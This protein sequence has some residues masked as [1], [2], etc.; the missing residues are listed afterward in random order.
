MIQEARTL[1]SPKRQNQRFH[2]YDR[3]NKKNNY[4]IFTPS[5][6][7]TEL[8][9]Y[10]PKT[11]FNEFS[12]ME[13]NS[14]CCKSFQTLNNH[15]STGKKSRKNDTDSFVKPFGLNLQNLQSESKRQQASYTSH[16]EQ[17]PHFNFSLKSICLDTKPKKKVLL[18]TEDIIMER[19]EK[20]KLEIEK[21]KRTN[22]ENI[23]KM[24]YGNFGTT[25]LGKKRDSFNSMNCEPFEKKSYEL[26]NS[27]PLKTEDN[28]DNNC[29]EDDFLSLTDNISKLSVMNSPCKESMKSM[30]SSN[31]ISTTGQSTNKAPFISIFD[32]TKEEK[33]QN[34]LK[35]KA[36]KKEEKLKELKKQSLLSKLNMNIFQKKPIKMEVEN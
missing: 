29:L 14:T 9:G 34:D 6:N 8:T 20:E 7:K 31:T 16:S 18:S 12:T 28:F 22:R 23:E 35:E 1:I 27:I 25:M 33:R 15:T 24:F 19:I 17:H 2:Q 5:G 30:K 10:E 13:A 26:I 36:K 32:M 21:L 4:N 3:S 11:V